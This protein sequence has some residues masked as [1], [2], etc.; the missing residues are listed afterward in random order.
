MSTV[1]DEWQEYDCP[2]CGIDFDLDGSDMVVEDE[3]FHCPGCG[4]MHVA[5]PE[6][7]TQYSLSSGGDLTTVPL[8]NRLTA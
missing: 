3:S 4:Q 6:L 5:T 7:I 8:R 2:V 1:A